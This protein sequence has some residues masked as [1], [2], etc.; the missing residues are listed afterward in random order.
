MR[1]ISVNC[2]FCWKILKKKNIL[3][4]RLI[5]EEREGTNLREEKKISITPDGAVY[6]SGK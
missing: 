6:Y 3:Y 1:Y 4:S 2:A 5:L